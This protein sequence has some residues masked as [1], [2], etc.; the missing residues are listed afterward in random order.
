MTLIEAILKRH[1]AGEKNVKAI[2]DAEGVSPGYVYGVLR[3]HRPERKRKPRE[4][5]S[6][7]RRLILGLLAQ[8]IPPPR[9]AFLAQCTPAYVYQLIDQESAA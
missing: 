3:E 9:T 5:T 6:E 1:D 7:K 4:R 8:G 2:A